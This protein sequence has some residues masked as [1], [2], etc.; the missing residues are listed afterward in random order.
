MSVSKQNS[1]G[2]DMGSSVKGETSI[3]GPHL[4]GDTKNRT[5]PR[6]KSITICGTANSF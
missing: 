3:P 5:S 1:Q 6:E 2:R 4:A